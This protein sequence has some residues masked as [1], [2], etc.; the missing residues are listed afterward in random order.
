MTCC[1]LVTYC[2]MNVNGVWPEAQQSSGQTPF[3]FTGSRFVLLQTRENL[4][5]QC[6]GKWKNVLVLS[7]IHFLILLTNRQTHKCRRKHKNLDQ[8]SRVVMC[9]LTYPASVVIRVLTKALKTTIIV[10]QD[11]HQRPN[12][13]LKDQISYG[14]QMSV[15]YHYHHIAPH[16]LQAHMSIWL[17][18]CVFW[19]PP[20]NPFSDLYLAANC[21]WGPP[22]Q[23]HSNQLTIL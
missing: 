15:F 19:C 3:K 20:F 7:W 10:S 17:W 8:G 9:S 18:A 6:F 12:N 13:T 21:L 4:P 1:V 22:L 23:G 14:W 5:Y 2:C 11:Y 16:H